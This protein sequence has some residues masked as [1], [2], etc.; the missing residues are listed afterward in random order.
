MPYSNTLKTRILLGDVAGVLGP[1]SSEVTGFLD[2]GT[3]DMARRGL[4]FQ[5]RESIALT[6]NTRVYT[7]S[8]DH[9]DTFTLFRE[10]YA[11]SLRLLDQESHVWYLTV[12]ETGIL[13]FTDTAPA[14]HLLLNASNIFWIQIASPDSTPWFIYPSVTGVLIASTVQ[15]TGAGTTQTVQLRDEWGTP[16]YPSVSN[17]GIVS[18]SMTG[19]ATLAAAALNDE[20]LKRIE[21][22]A[23]Q[24]TDARLT[25]GPPKFYAITGKLLWLKPTP[26]ARYQLKHY[27]FADAGSLLVPHPARYLPV[28]FATAMGL[29]RSRR[30]GPAKQLLAMYGMEMTAHAGSLW[31]GS[32]DGL[33]V[34]KLPTT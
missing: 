7:L 3:R 20:V 5:K 25:S 29:Q 1:S 10:R 9:V 15:P 19:T 8:S 24:R 31:P 33:S 26:D 14:G 23:I 22:E 21:P 17:T 34:Y 4:L 6:A 12:S 27:F 30:L 13:G 16:W 32:R 2:R 28:L 11:V 18:A